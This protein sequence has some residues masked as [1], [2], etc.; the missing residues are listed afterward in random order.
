MVKIGDMTIQNQADILPVIFVGYVSYDLS[1]TGALIITG[2][3]FKPRNI[4]LLGAAGSGAWSINVITA[5]GGGTNQIRGVASYNEETADRVN[6]V[7]PHTIVTGT[8]AEAYLQ[9]ASYDTNGFTLTKSK[10]GSP[11]GTGHISYW[12]FK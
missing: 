1:T 4:I 7:G 3:G 8:G 2:I 9:L 11:T 5:P 10:S 12:A 6:T